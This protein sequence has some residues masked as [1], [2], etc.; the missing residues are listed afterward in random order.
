MRSLIPGNTINHQPRLTIY[1]Y[2]T[3]HQIRTTISIIIH[4]HH[5]TGQLTIESLHFIKRDRDQTLVYNIKYISC[6]YPLHTYGYCNADLIIIIS[7][8]VT[9][10]WPILTELRKYYKSRYDPYFYIHTVQWDD[11]PTQPSG[12]RPTALHGTGGLSR[13]IA[14]LRTATKK[15]IMDNIYPNNF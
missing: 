6:H 9:V 15:F 2:H 1:L 12:L 5:H 14:K 4:D 3:I 7:Q 11:N 13:Q 8:L 10:T